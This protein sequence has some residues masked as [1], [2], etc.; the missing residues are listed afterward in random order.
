MAS[1]NVNEYGDLSEKVMRSV[2]SVCVQEE[3]LKV[4][5]RSWDTGCG[6]SSFAD[7]STLAAVM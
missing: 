2:V 3:A 1:G 5:V 7:M 4:L 6:R